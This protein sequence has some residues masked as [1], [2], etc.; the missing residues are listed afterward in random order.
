MVHVVQ[1]ADHRGGK[2]RVRGKRDPNPAKRRKTEGT[3]SE[4]NKWPTCW[5][6]NESSFYP[7]KVVVRHAEGW[8]SRLIVPDVRRP[9]PGLLWFSGKRLVVT[10]THLVS[11]SDLMIPI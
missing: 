4:G 7:Q 10:W 8:R 9:H 1:R 6:T 3:E 2:F 5:K 11:N